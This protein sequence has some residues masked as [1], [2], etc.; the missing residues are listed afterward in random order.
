MVKDEKEPW[1]AKYCIPSFMWPN[2]DEVTCAWSPYLH[3]FLH[4]FLENAFNAWMP[5][6]PYSAV[7]LWVVRHIEIQTPFVS[8]LFS[9]AATIRQR[10]RVWERVIQH[11]MSLWAHPNSQ[12]H[13]IMGPGLR[14]LGASCGRSDGRSRLGVREWWG[15]WVGRDRGA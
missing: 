6:S 12:P 8:V 2:M 3:V 11:S 4:D 13:G 10:A 1:I 15:W 9:A 5:T 7:S 14:K